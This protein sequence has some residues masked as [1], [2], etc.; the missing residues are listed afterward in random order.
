MKKEIDELINKTGKFEIIGKDG[1]HMRMGWVEQTPWNRIEEQL[2]QFDELTKNYDNFIFTAMGGSINTIKA[3]KKIYNAK[4]IWTIDSLD[5][6]AQKEMEN[7]ENPM[8]IAISKSG[9]TRETQVLADR[10]QKPTIWLKDTNGDMPIQFNE[11]NDIGGRFSAPETM[12]FWAP[13]FLIMNKDMEKLK[14][15]W[16][17]FREKRNEIVQKIWVKGEELAKKNCQ[18]FQIDTNKALEVWITQLFEESLGSKIEGYFPKTIVSQEKIRGFETIEL[19]NEMTEAMFEAQILVAS[20][21]YYKD[22]VFV[23]QPSVEKYKK[24]MRGEILDEEIEVEDQPKK[25]IEIINYGYLKEEEREKLKQ[26]YQEKY[27]Q[28]IILVF[29]GSDWNHHSYQAA[30]G[31]PE[32]LFILIDRGTDPILTQIARA[33]YETI[34][35]RAILR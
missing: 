21:A 28:K 24:A 9:T 18:Y 15:V 5:P 26:T 4:N 11:S 12:V 14:K 27:P 16:I 25:I 23:N 19:S 32:T 13:L 17:N 29:E 8:V 2:N 35:G 33:T 34:K 20:I 31:N 1:E 22:I 10:L 3:L 7:I 6:R 30:Y